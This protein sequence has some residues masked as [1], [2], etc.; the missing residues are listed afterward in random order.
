MQEFREG[1]LGSATRL[2]EGMLGQ[3]QEKQM[4]V[5]WDGLGGL[6]LCHSFSKGLSS[7]PTGRGGTAESHSLH[8]ELALSHSQHGTWQVRKGLHGS[9]ALIFAPSLG[10]CP[11]STVR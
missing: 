8:W 9:P 6:V 11:V 4:G 2:P 1:V 5:W 7:D 3:P 10:L